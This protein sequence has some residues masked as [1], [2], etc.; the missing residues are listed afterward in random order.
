MASSWSGTIVVTEKGGKHTIGA[1]LPPGVW[2]DD[3]VQRLVASGPYAP[4]TFPKLAAEEKIELWF[5]QRR[6]EGFTFTRLAT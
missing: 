5:M 2:T 6:S 4:T 3:E 1:E